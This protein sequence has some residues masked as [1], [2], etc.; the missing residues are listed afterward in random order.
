MARC[1]I[2]YGTAH[3]GGNVPLQHV[4]AWPILF[5]F[6]VCLRQAFYMLGGVLHFDTAIYAYVYH[7]LK[8]LII[9]N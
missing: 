9:C 2:G 3:S 6:G 8:P 1:K 4:L 5:L 7:S